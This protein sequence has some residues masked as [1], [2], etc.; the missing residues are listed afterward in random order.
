MCFGTR[1]CAAA[2]LHCSCGYTCMTAPNILLNQQQQRPAQST[3]AITWDANAYAA[4]AA[5]KQHCDA[6]SSESNLARE[7]RALVVYN[8]VVHA[9]REH[10]EKEC[11]DGARRTN[12]QQQ[13]PS[14]QVTCIQ[15][16]ADQTGLAAPDT[17]ATAPAG[18]TIDPNAEPVR[19][20]AGA[21]VHATATARRR[22]PV[23][24]HPAQPAPAPGTGQKPKSCKL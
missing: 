19:A 7:H 17:F 24:L 22:S 21:S 10:I 16:R 5:T 15:H 4:A 18:H 9:C 14:V 11:V 6:P 3:A 23:G 1:H 2:S 8:S 12:H 13:Q 20:R